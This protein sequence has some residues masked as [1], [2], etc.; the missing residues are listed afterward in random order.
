MHS[1]QA[2]GERIYSTALGEGQEIPGLASL[3]LSSRLQVP[4]DDSTAGLSHSGLY[5]VLT[6][7]A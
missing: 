6:G 7:A 4:T 2:S 5:S 3:S 1:V